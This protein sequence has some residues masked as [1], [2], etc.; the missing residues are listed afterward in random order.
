VPPLLASP[1]LRRELPL[2]LGLLLALIWLLQPDWFRFGY[3]HGA[4]WDTYL[5]ST[6][7]MWLD[8]EH[9]RYNEWRRPLYPWLLGLLGGGGSYVLAAQWLALLGTLATVTGS[10][11]LARALAGPWA[12]GLA[13]L[14]AAW[15]PVVVDGSFWVNPYPL[16]GGVTA[17]ALAAAAWACRWPGWWASGL[18]G[19]LGGL[20]WALDSRGL[21]VA[22]A[23]PLLVALGPAPWRRR[24][25]LVVLAVAGIAVGQLGDRALVTVHDLR[26]R[27]LSSQL[28]LQHGLG[29]GPEVAGEP[30][31]RAEAEACADVR[32]QALTPAAL[33][34]DCASHRRRLSAGTLRAEGELPP[35]L[36]S[37]GLLLLTLIPAG[38][39]RRSS[40]ASALIW[41]PSLAALLLGMSWVP[42]VERYLLPVAAL[43]AALAPVALLRAG[44]LV[45]R[46][47]PSRW[48]RA[49][50]PSLAALW[51]LAVHPS[52]HPHALTHPLWHIAA[53][54]AEIPAR[55]DPRVA[56]ARWAQESIGPEDLLLDC[57]ELRLEPM[58][59]PRRLSL[60]DAPPHD[61]ACRERMAEP[62]QVEGE[63]WLLSVHGGGW[64][65]AERLV[66][67]AWIEQQ[68]WV[69]QPFDAPLDP[70]K[71]QG[72]IRPLRRWRWRE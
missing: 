23:V 43:L 44:S 6:G 66:T 12:G 7:A 45:A 36:P 62:P 61:R 69:E 63:L 15:L 4:D 65:P 8:P 22:A 40:L 29:R 58:L 52:I 19:L 60:W 48:L 21:A 54:K 51:L 25:L 49:V 72:A 35:L 3:P 32:H 34:D 56:M 11:L 64:L 70:M 16:A 57:A 27:P 42:Y 31:V 50:G 18:S 5:A 41:L 71:D 26:L 68:G 28:E 13:A 24:A 55:H 1:R 38:W 20:C 9:F 67:P 53:R 14:S 2:L 30:M 37:V 33:L 17:L 59:L 47:G 10:G 39:G 46:L